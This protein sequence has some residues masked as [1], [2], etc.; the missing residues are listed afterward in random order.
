MLVLELK[1]GVRRGSEGQGLVVTLQEGG[2]LR[3]RDNSGQKGPLE[4]I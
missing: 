3:S 4:V 1:A 2:D